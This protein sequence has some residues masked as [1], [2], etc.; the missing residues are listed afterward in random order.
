[1]RIRSCRRRRRFRSG[2]R[3][4]GDS[5]TRVGAAASQQLLSEF[6]AALTAALDYDLI[7]QRL[8]HFALPLLGDWC[9]VDLALRDDDGTIISVRRAAARHVDAERS[10]TLDALNRAYP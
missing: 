6:S 7:A 10:A 9:V 2:D 4:T 8:A 5:T 3:L 1:M